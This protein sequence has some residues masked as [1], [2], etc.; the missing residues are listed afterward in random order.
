MRN[1]N[2]HKRPPLDTR[3]SGKRFAK[4]GSFLATK[5]ESSIKFQLVRISSF[6]EI[7]KQKNRQTQRQTITLEI[8]LEGWGKD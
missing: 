4:S 1:E 6:G 3:F 7:N 8:G 5:R 2:I